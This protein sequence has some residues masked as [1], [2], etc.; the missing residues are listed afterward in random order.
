MNNAWIYCRTA[1]DNLFKLE[2]QRKT[3]IE[4]AEL[5]NYNI[6]GI[7]MESCSGLCMKRKGLAELSNAVRN[8]L[9]DIV[10]MKDFACIGRDLKKTFDYLEFLNK[11][12]VK[13]ITMNEGNNL[14][15]NCNEDTKSLNDLLK[16][17]YNDEILRVVL[18]RIDCKK[19]GFKFDRL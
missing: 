2:E 13:L 4:Y 10:L 15:M 9:I 11:H 18:N 12:N 14:A 8:G 16:K 1:Q 19:G 7:S 6:I 17:A 3:L 5:H